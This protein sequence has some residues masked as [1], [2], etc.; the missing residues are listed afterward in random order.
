[1]NPKFTGYLGHGLVALDRLNCQLS[2]KRCLTLLP[3][4][5]FRF[6]LPALTLWLAIL[7]LISLS[8]FAQAFTS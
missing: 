8:S 2:H 4:H 7:H 6:T 1:M 5:Y 3:F